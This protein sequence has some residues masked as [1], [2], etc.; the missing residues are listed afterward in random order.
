MPIEKNKF[1]LDSNLWISFLI[2]NNLPGIEEILCNDNFQMIFSRE[3]LD[4]FLDVAQRPKFQKYFSQN[5]INIAL[6]II[7]DFS[8]FIDVTSVVKL[9]R[10]PKDDFLLA[11]AIDS[12]AKYLVTG[13]MDLL[14]LQFIEKTKIITIAEFLKEV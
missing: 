7:I 1:I 9:C 3:L 14:D 11:L 12:Q 6:E 13:D 4:E 2:K 8:E 5:E 10:D